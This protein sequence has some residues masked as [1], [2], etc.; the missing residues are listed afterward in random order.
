MTVLAEAMRRPLEAVETLRIVS[1]TLDR[2]RVRWWI[3]YG[4]L[5][6]FMR[7]GGMIA[8]DSD[9]DLGILAEDMP[10]VL[11]TE[12]RLKSRGLDACY[13]PPGPHRFASGDWFHVTRAPD[14]PNGVDVFPWYTHGHM[15][16][17]ARYC[18]ADTIKGREF[19]VERLLPLTRGAWEGVDVAV[20][21]DPAWLVAHRYGPD[22]RTP[23]DYKDG[24]PAMEP[25]P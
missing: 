4:T 6:G 8:W 23:V 22:W 24:V 10:R 19:P 12:P 16:D 13:H 17:R 7:E 3:D 15:L 21:A 14:N 11:A 20:P 5:L 1:H 9:I 25:T 2:L 18:D